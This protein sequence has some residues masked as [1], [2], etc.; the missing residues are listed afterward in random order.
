MNVISLTQLLVC[1]T[2]VSNAQWNSSGAYLHTTAQNVGIGIAQPASPLHVYQSVNGELSVIIQNSYAPGTRTFLTSF[3]GKSSIQTDTYFTIATNGGGWSD[4]FIVTNA[5]KVGVGTST[6]TSRMEVHDS[7]AEANLMVFNTD[8][9]G[10]RTYLTSSPNQSSIQTDKNFAIRTNGGG[11]WRDKVTVT[12]GGNVG[13]GTSNP[14]E[15]L[16]VKGKIHAQ[17]V[18]VDLAVPGPDYVFDK[19]Y[20]LQTLS[21]LERYISINN[22][23]PDVPAANEMEENGVNLGEINM[24]LL[25]KIE[26]LTL[27]VIEL[28]KQQ[29]VN[30]QRIEDQQV[31]LNLSKKVCQEHK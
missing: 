29:Q 28:K 21:E 14:D 2:L 9:N 19:N 18:K 20:E 12:N 30:A 16:A 4:K 7:G 27:Y 10:A 22:H 24:I 6:P 15:L 1:V 13:I 8:A 31:E 25:R 11:V 23:L 26:E 3:P 5:G 17:E